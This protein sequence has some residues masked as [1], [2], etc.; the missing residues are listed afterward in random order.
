MTS[1]LKKIS[2][3][4][5]SVK[6]MEIKTIQN[7][8]IISELKSITSSGHIF[9]QLNCVNASNILQDNLKDHQ[10]RIF[11]GN[12]QFYLFNDNL[13]VSI[14]IMRQ[15]NINIDSKIQLFIANGSNYYEIYD[16]RSPSIQRSGILNVTKIGSFVNGELNLTISKI[17]HD[18]KGILLQAGISVSVQNLFIQLCFKTFF[19]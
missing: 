13:D 9:V 10:N 5:I 17:S 6:L 3:H 16:I 14:Q 11:D 7:K 19:L 2:N 1:V 4:P 12:Y 8:K 18:L 15:F